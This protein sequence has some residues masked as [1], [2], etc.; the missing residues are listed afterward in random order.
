MNHTLRWI[1]SGLLAVLITGCQLL[2]PF[3]RPAPP[4]VLP[5]NISKEDLVRHLNGHIANLHSW[6]SSDVSISTT[7]P[8]GFPIK[9]DAEIAVQSPR[10]FRLLASSFLGSEADFGSNADRFWFWMRRAK[11]KHIFTLRHNQFQHVQKK[12]PL[13]FKPDGLMEAL[14][15]VPL[16][17]SKLVMQTREPGSTLV[18]LVENRTLP[19]GQEIHRVLL[20][21]TCQ[22]HIVEQSLHDTYGRTIVRAEFNRYQRDPQTGISLPH[23]INFDWP[24]NKMAMS[25]RIGQITVNPQFLPNHLWQMPSYKG[26]PLMDMA[27]ILELSPRQAAGTKYR[28]EDGRPG[29]IRIQSAFGNSSS[30]P[31]GRPHFADE[32]ERQI[33]E[34]PRFADEENGNVFRAGNRERRSPSP[35]EQRPIRQTN[36]RRP[37]ADSPNQRPGRINLRHYP[38]R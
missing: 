12:F 23:E 22:G 32:T 15:M 9:L 36:G 19:N 10:N 14:G 33:S 34:R 17:A 1:C 6:R 35:F 5:E 31:D 37:D 7:T 26:Y 18:S 29:R 24:Q 27:K 8:Q 13:P 28:S 30:T 20:V 38:P 11:P 3:L 4:C 16:D 2:P 25:M 21:D